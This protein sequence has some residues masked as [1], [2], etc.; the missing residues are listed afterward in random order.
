MI[1]EHRK[2]CFRCLLYLTLF[3]FISPASAVT[4]EEVNQRNLEAEQ[5]CEANRNYESASGNEILSAISGDNWGFLW[6]LV[7][8]EARFAI[9]EQLTPKKLAKLVVKITPELADK[10][11]S[12]SGSEKTDAEK[13]KEL[14]ILIEEFMSTQYGYANDN[15]A[16]IKAAPALGMVRIGWADDIHYKKCNTWLIKYVCHGPDCWWE[17]YWATLHDSIYPDYDVYRVIN[18]TE[19]YLATVQGGVQ[20]KRNT[21][22]N[23]SF[24][25]PE[26]LLKSIGK[27]LVKNQVAK[28]IEKDSSNPPVVNIYSDFYAD[29]YQD[30]V[31]RYKLV[32]SDPGGVRQCSKTI[33]TFSYYLDYDMDADGV[34]DFVD[35]NWY[36]SQLGEIYAPILVPVFSLLLL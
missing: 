15:K 12:I 29:I 18:G 22:V 13:G 32:G 8:D 35:K 5:A 16:Y 1:A 34:P 24:S 33:N 20:S 25:S 30:S 28:L 10:I 14:E 11:N 26:T 6:G 21:Q 36:S 4:Q 2:Y 23:I 7:N 27:D 31:I 17:G 19:K 9:C 3:V